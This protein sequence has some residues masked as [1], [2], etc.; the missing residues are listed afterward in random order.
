LEREERAR[1][2]KERERRLEFEREERAR[3]LELE[4]EDRARQE[5]EREKNSLKLIDRKE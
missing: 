5:K 2:A 3:Q 1:Q 4:R